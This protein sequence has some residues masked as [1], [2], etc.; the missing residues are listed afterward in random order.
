MSE[1]YIVHPSAFV[2]DEVSIGNGTRIW[3]QVQVRKGAKIG[4][5]CVIGKASFIDFDVK[6]GNNVKVQNF[7]SVYHGVTVE[8]DVFIGPHVCF[9]NDMK[10]RA[11]NPS[12]QVVHSL[13]KKGA[14]IGANS[15]IVCG[16]TIGEYAMIGAGSVVT[17]EV[18]PFSLVY[19]NPARLQGYVCYCG[20]ILLKTTTPLQE[21]HKL[22]CKTCGQIVEIP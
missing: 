8:D 13:I 10:P 2:E 6:L 21:G 9:T 17:K 16:H 12:W 14:S 4:E 15:T 18:H 7:V 20:E 11:V 1:K 3:H 22:E 19:G 5:N